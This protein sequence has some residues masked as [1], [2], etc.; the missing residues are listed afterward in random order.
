MFSFMFAMVF[1]FSVGLVTANYGALVR[2]KIPGMPFFL[3]SLFIVYY[4]RKEKVKE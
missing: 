4:L 2:Y 3:I 1:L